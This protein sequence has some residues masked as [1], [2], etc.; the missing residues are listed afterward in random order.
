MKKFWRFENVKCLC[1]NEIKCRVDGI[2]RK[3]GS[4]KRLVRE[5]WSCAS[6]GN[7]GQVADLVVDSGQ[8]KLSTGL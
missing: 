3:D 7:S 8:D 2:V 6:C 1:G 5:A 4:L